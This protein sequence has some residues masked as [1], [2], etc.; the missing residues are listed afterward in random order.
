MTRGGPAAYDRCVG[1]SVTCSRQ[2]VFDVSV[3]VG[4]FLAVG[5]LVLVA[6]GSPDSAVGTAC[7]LG[8]AAVQAGSLVFMRRYP[9]WGMAVAVAAG[10]GLEV[11]TP[12]VGWL[13]QVAAV[14]CCYAR[15]RPPRRSLWV[16]ALLVAG[17]PWKLTH[18]NWQSMLLAIAAP[19]I[20][21]SL[22]ELG[23]T[24]SLRRADERRRLVAQ[25]RG[26]IAR[27]LH[28]VL[29]HTV[30]VIVVQANAAEDVFDA[31]PDLARKALASI[32][33]AARATLGELRVLLQTISADAD[34]QPGA[35][36]P[37]LGQ[38]DQLAASLGATGLRVELRRE[39][40]T[41]ALPAAVQLSAY[42]IVQESLTNTLRHSQAT[43]AHVTV[44]GGPGSVQ[45]EVRDDGPARPA[46]RAEGSRR[47]ILGMRER[48]RLLGGTLD[49]GPLP[50]GGFRV[51]A[52]LPLEPAT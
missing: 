3:A 31:R 29:A 7:A 23:R 48:A 17:T 49:A 15:L 12:G 5:S 30:S 45:V 44:R 10:I 26:R 20:G 51:R 25:E 40:L 27:E 28:D 8:F 41:D 2:R 11:L 35:P 13:G 32:G 52:D 37:G 42:R 14:L 1:Q 38:L 39:A 24:R 19:V 6:P 18:G 50:G 36:Q 33:T 21:W 34:A 4:L 9:E 16:L 22:G 46:G 47:G 43:S